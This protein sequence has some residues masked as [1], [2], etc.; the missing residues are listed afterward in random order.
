MAKMIN[1]V[2]VQQF[3]KGWWGENG[4]GKALLTALGLP[5]DEIPFEVEQYLTE[6]KFSV[7]LN[8]GFVANVT[9]NK[10]DAYFEFACKWPDR[11]YCFKLFREWDGAE[12]DTIIRMESYSIGECTRKIMTSKSI[13]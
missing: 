13:L 6:G 9:I 2:V 11:K 8:D 5:S 7:R 1:G 3:I 12:L 10:Q 4:E